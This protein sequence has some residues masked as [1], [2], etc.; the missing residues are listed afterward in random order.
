MGERAP[1]GREKSRERCTANRLMSVRSLRERNTGTEPPYPT[2][3]PSPTVTPSNPTH[4]GLR[5]LTE[6]RLVMN[7]STIVR[8]TK[9]SIIFYGLGSVWA[10]EEGRRFEV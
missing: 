2:G 4:D 9:V 8:L 6:E 1:D 10:G 7:I 3:F 5:I